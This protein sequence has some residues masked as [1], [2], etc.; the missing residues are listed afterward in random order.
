MFAAKNKFRFEL[1]SIEESVVFY[2]ITIEA[3]NIGA[4]PQLN[5]IKL[6]LFHLI[7]N[8]VNRQHSYF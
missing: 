7:L 8:Y 1:L 5:L 3:L 2:K 6:I 4:L